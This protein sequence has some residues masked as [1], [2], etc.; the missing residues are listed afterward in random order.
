MSNRLRFAAQ[1]QPSAVQGNHFWS[2]GYCVDT[3]GM[4]TEMIRKYVKYQDNK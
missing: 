1:R 4:D 2:I 3:V